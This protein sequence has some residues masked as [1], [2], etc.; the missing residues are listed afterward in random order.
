MKLVRRFQSEES[1]VPQRIHRRIEFR[2]SFVESVEETK[3]AVTFSELQV[4]EIMK[5]GA[6]EEGQMV[7]GVIS[8]HSYEDYR[9]PGIRRRLV[10]FVL[11]EFS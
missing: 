11:I 9:E 10:I 6:R 5:L 8:K 4:V 2:A 1:F 3:H 7:T